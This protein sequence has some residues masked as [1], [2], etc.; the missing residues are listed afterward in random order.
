MSKEE[1]DT[2]CCRT[3]CENPL[4]QNY[5]ETQWQSN[6]HTHSGC[7]FSIV[8][9][10]CHFGNI[11]NRIGHFSRSVFTHFVHQFLSVVSAFPN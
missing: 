10:E 5:W 3:Q 7:G 6:S 11:G 2:Q 1:K 4:D 9:H 8:F